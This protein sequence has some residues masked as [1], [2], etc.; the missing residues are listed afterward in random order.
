MLGPLRKD[1]WWSQ[2]RDLY[3]LLL[4]FR[5]SKVSDERDIIYALL[6]ISSDAL[7]TDILRADYTKTT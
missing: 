3:T 2:K 6:G 4:K 1:S 5:G 7:D